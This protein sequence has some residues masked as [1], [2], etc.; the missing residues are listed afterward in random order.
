MTEKLN[1]ENIEKFEYPRYC[2]IGIVLK[3]PPNTENLLYESFQIS[4][5]EE[6]KK[7]KIQELEIVNGEIIVKLKKEKD[8]EYLVPDSI[9]EILIIFFHRLIPTNFLLIS[10][11]I[12]KII[13]INF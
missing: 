3:I 8:D 7:G 12:K 1:F 2:N 13:E 11:L 6:L 10:L 5:K 4:L 9:M